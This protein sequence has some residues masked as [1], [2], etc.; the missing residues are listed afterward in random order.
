[1]ADRE[2]IGGMPQPTPRERQWAIDLAK[3]IVEVARGVSDPDE[4][5]GQVARELYCAV[6]MLN[7][8]HS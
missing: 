6:A 2:Y 5:E 3:I 1:M 4:A 8:S 7:G